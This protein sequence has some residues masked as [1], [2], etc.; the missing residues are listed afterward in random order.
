MLLRGLQQGLGHA[1]HDQS[2]TKELEQDPTALADCAELSTVLLRSRLCFF[3]LKMCVR[4]A[5]LAQHAQVQNPKDCFS[6]QHVLTCFGMQDGLYRH[7]S[8][9]ILVSLTA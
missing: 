5:M 8:T 2:Q 6:H 1:M 9:G 3:D 4:P 7:C